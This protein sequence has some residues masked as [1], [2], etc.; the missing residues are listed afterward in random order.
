MSK[1][2]Q[3][4]ELIN[5]ISVDGSGNVVLSSGQLVA[6]QSYVSTAITNLVNSAPSTLDTLNELATAL[7]NDPNFATTIATSIGTKQAQLNGTG[8]VKISGTTISY[9]NSTYLTTSTASSTYLPLTGGTLTGPLTINYGGGHFTLVRNAF[10]TF[11]FGTGIGSGISG[12]VI[13]DVTAG[14]NPLIIAQTTGNATFSGEVSVGSSLV[15]AAANPFIYGGTAVGGVGISN[16]GGQSYIKI[17]GASHATLANVIQ[18]VNGSSTSFTVSSAGV[19]NF[20]SRVNI[21]GA[22]DNASYALNVYGDAT[23]NGTRATPAYIYA[24]RGGDDSKLILKA[25]STAGYFSQIDV[26]GWNGTGT[27]A[28]IALNSGS[29]TGIYVKLG[30]NIGVG[31]V[32]PSAKLDVYAGADATSNT[33]L[34]GQIIRNE[35][36]GAATGYGSGL[37]LKLSSDG[38]PYKWAGIA[39]VAGTGY[40]NRTDLGLFTAATSTADA[41]EKVRI[42]GDGYFGIGT[43]SPGSK[44]SVSG[45]NSGSNPLVDLT[46]SGTGTFQR[47]VRLLNSGMNAGDHIMYAVGQADSARNMGQFY[48]QYNG[49]GST[50]N[51]ISM[52]MHS[53]DDV[54]NILGS[55]NV[56]VGTINPLEKFSVNGNIHI[57]G[58][59][60]SLLF[61]TDASGRSISQY[62]TNL[63]E[64]HIV[65]ARGNSSRFVLGNGS[66]SLGTSA[67]PQFYIDT[68]TG[69][70]G[71]GTTDF[72]NLAFGST[73]LK[74]AGTRATL[75]LQS[76]GT[77][78]TIALIA[79]NNTA[80]AMHMN[81][82]NTGAFRWYSYV[83]AGET[84]SLLGNG[85]LGLGVSSPD[86]RLH[87]GG[88]I[89]VSNNSQTFR[90]AITTHGQTGTYTQI[91][92]YFNKNAW[93]SVTYDIKLASA[94]GSHHTAGGYYSNPGIGSHVNSINTGTGLTMTFAAGSQSGDTQGAAWT[95]SGATMIHPILTIDIACGNGYQVNPDDIVVQFT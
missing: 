27:P 54:F 80:T 42:T 35:G 40:S 47:G 41:T 71:M 52:G 18:F 67:T 65:N 26:S 3:I 95:F 31:T 14:T 17:H 51:R 20:N 39:A 66:I 34:W 23:F 50:S 6:T 38:E 7:G 30:N 69:N 81:F 15:L 79:A 55:G 89:L 86:A 10:N 29:G 1:N 83:S 76:S 84:F 48:F 19:T 91:K 9:D 8:F 64:F 49:A 93:G 53:V 22:V 12:L 5:Y 88:A 92:V 57:A 46:A 87:V 56:G 62:V 75:A 85:R 90:R 4:S 74:V 78:S 77:L 45:S 37:K 11:S 24:I 60:N 94:G 16:I 63:Y 2:T 44:L 43:V 73:L 32:T 25:G 61:D 68:S 13:S 58:V 82:E 70:V 36:N 59:G 33:I 21:N 72:S 28:Y